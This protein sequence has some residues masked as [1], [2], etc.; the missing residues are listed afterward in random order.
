MGSRV[1]GKEPLSPQDRKWIR[2]QRLQVEPINRGVSWL[3]AK[4]TTGLLALLSAAAFLLVLACA[5]VAGLLLA[6]AAAQ[7]QQNAIRLA[8]G[9]SRARLTQQWLMEGAVLAFMGG[10][11]GLL[12]AR[13]CL[14]LLDGML[15][16]MRNIMTQP[17]PAALHLSV[18]L[19]VFA[20]A[21]LICCGAAL[22]TAI[23]PAWHAARADLM[24]PLK[25]VSLN[26]RGSRVRALLVAC[27]VAIC[28]MVTCNAGLMLATL[29][30]LE[31]IDPG[32]KTERIVT[33]SIDSGLQKYDQ[34]Q[35]YALALRLA[36]ETR[37]LPGVAAAA[38]AVKP[39]LRG[40]GMRMSVAPI[41]GT[42]SAN[43]VLNSDM[44][45]VS[46]G[47]FEALGIRLLAGRTFDNRDLRPSKPKPVVVNE[48]F[49]RRFFPGR[50][51]SKANGVGQRFGDA[52]GDPLEPRYEVVGVAADSKYRSLREAPFPAVFG[53][54]RTADDLPQPSFELIV[55]SSGDPASIIS[56]VRSTLRSIDARLPFREVHTLREDLAASLW[57]EHTLVR[58][59]SLF[60]TLAVLLAAIGLY[61]LL[62]LVVVERSREIGIRMALGA[63][64]VDV[65]EATALGAL[66]FVGA[67]IASGLLGA[68]ATAALL[69]S[70]LFGVSPWDAQTLGSSVAVVAAC[71]AMA[72]L[73]PAARAARLDPSATLR[74]SA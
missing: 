15:P 53:C 11:G 43:E 49:V 2:R 14:P 4:F 72:T 59:G 9:A 58:L 50:F 7:E 24:T 31:T 41:G 71:A 67:G 25:A 37:N 68:V 55:R 36:D 13:A 30:N 5:N 45:S 65:L 74:Q 64:P 70:V 29:R 8:V 17:L 39:L 34:A 56:A 18:D 21:V 10:V 27:Q 62:S 61:G 51:F 12:M 6:R 3:R 23:A 54:I 47:Y 46:P 42:R 28:T 52:Q 66:L 26:R 1:C 35:T 22:L 48:T 40:A 57:S 16:P 60:S 38:F 69:R 63:R 33:F 44:N 19:R 20:F 32:F 73:W